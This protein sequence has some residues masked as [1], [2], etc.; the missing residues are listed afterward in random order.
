MTDLI[1]RFLTASLDHWLTRWLTGLPQANDLQWIL[2]Q[3][4]IHMFKKLQII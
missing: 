1:T 2:E 4:Q 3:F